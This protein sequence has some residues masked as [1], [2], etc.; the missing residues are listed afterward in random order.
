MPNINVETKINKPAS[1]VFSRFGEGLFEKLIPPF[2][3]VERNDGIELDAYISVSFKI[4]FMKTWHSKIVDKNRDSE[5]FWF[6]DKGISGIPFGIKKWTHIHRVKEL[7]E[8]QCVI[9]DEIYFETNYKILD[10]LCKFIFT[11]AMKSRKK[12]YKNFFDYE[13]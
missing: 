7:S 9:V 13:V 12:T 5:G 10:V 2:A 6:T 8:S 11:Q 1:E 3:K 4:P